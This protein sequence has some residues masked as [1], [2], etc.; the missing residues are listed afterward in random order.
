MSINVLYL[1]HKASSFFPPWP[2]VRKHVS[3]SGENI[4]KYVE[5]ISKLL[6]ILKKP[7]SILDVADI[8]LFVLSEL[9]ILNV[10]IS[11]TRTWNWLSYYMP[12]CADVQNN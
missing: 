9:P 10:Q 3:V 12:V 7:L 5:K 1:L 2:A 4:H 11:V 6:V 8:V